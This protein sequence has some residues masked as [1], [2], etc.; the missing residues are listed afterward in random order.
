[1]NWEKLLKS[2]KTEKSYPLK[3]K[4][5][6]DAA[7]EIWSKTK[8]T[9]SAWVNLLN[10]YILELIKMHPEKDTE[11]EVE[12]FVKY[13]RDWL[14]EMTKE[15]KMLKSEKSVT[16]LK[17]PGRNNSK[18]R[19]LLTD[20]SFD[21]QLKLFE[22]TFD[23]YA[24]A[25]FMQP[26]ITYKKFF[27][28]NEN[29]AAK[30]LIPFSERKTDRAEFKENRNLVKE[31]YAKLQ[32]LMEKFKEHDST[33]GSR[34]NVPDTGRKLAHAQLVDLLKDAAE[35]LKANQ[36][37][38]WDEIETLMAKNYKSLQPK[39]RDKVLLISS[40]GDETV[41]T[42]IQYVPE[43]TPKLKAFFGHLKQEIEIKNYIVDDI[44]PQKALAYLRKFATKKKIR[45]KPIGGYLKVGL[46]INKF[47][48]GKGDANKRMW[49][50]PLLEG[51][52]K[53]NTQ[54]ENTLANEWFSEL[55]S[56]VI[57]EDAVKE[58]YVNQ[59]WEKYQTGNKEE[60]GIATLIGEKRM[61]ESQYKTLLNARLNS[62]DKNIYN[63]SR[64][65]YIQTMK[66]KI[67][68]IR[69]SVTKDFVDFIDLLATAL[70]EEN[71]QGE[72]KK[73]VEAFL[74]A[75]SPEERSDFI[76]KKRGRQ[77]SG[78]G[79][80]GG[81]KSPTQSKEGG[82]K[83]VVGLYKLPQ[84]S[85]KYSE[86]VKELH[87]Y[88]YLDN[89]PSNW[90]ALRSRFRTFRRNPD[91]R[92]LTKEFH[93][94]GLVGNIEE[95]TFKDANKLKTGSSLEKAIAYTLF[96]VYYT[97]SDLTGPNGVIT[98]SPSEKLKLSN[99][100]FI[101][102]IDFLGKVE[103]EVA[104]QKVLRRLLHTLND[105]YQEKIPEKERLRNILDGELDSD[106]DEFSK[107]LQMA[108]ENIRDGIKGL[109]ETRLNKIANNQMDAINSTYPE[110]LDD[111]VKEGLLREE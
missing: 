73:L 47:L 43:D 2:E 109:V 75:Y 21:L 86:I 78:F 97:S 79:V 40:L 10:G 44:T 72:N 50:N 32:P 17:L 63:E 26:T 60:D 83:Q 34:S 96:D 53:Q 64:N 46:K 84:T 98:S 11:Q 25:G 103:K 13:A 69:N 90:R 3:L 23:K 52:M 80:V 74:K 59:S 94:Q 101:S 105:K 62:P 51:I 29:S 38:D 111:L 57:R 28:W 58:N 37:P 99:S 45:G 27:E 102:V 100:N 6:Y 7:P 77:N 107:T 22:K 70:Q 71:P 110:L 87:N 82:A 4:D 56:I 49:L 31:N 19:N 76:S 39:R 61:D 16:K 41:Q 67:S 48:K 106:V 24:F 8:K 42:L 35:T 15:T 12:F 65:K 33:L 14:D 108:L 20:I 36:T 18:W 95:G 5:V 93:L 88:L 91:N 1:M 66:D 92:H 68:R 9:N 54:V 89:P 81:E 55:S 30:D 104:G 85:D